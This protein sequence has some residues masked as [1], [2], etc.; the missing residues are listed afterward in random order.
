[1]KPYE[2][3]SKNPHAEVGTQR[4]YRFENGRGASVVPMPNGLSELTWIVWTGEGLGDY[5]V[6][7]D[8]EPQADMDADDLDLCLGAIAACSPV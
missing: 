3:I 1:M 5:K 6:D 8:M 7:A 2:S 4:L